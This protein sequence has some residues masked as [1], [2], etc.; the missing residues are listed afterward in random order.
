MSRRLRVQ[1]QRGI[2]RSLVHTLPTAG[3]REGNM[4]W[5]N[6]RYRLQFW[7]SQLRRELRLQHQRIK[8]RSFLRGL[9]GGCQRH[10]HL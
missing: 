6:L 2:L 9:P 10:A 3:Q 8:L 1:Y 4:R 7:L 5:R